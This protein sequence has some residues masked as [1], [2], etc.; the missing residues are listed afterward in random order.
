MATSG[1]G[2]TSY[3]SVTITNNTTG[4][5]SSVSGMG[6]DGYANA[7]ANGTGILGQGGH[8]TAIT[9]ITNSAAIISSGDGI[10]GWG[11]KGASAVAY[12]GGYGSSASGGLG[13]GGVARANVV[14]TNSGTI[15]SGKAEGIDGYAAARATGGVLGNPGSA[16]KAVGGTATS[17]L[18]ISNSGAIN[19]SGTGINDVA[20]AWAGGYGSNTGPSGT[21]PGGSG[22]G[23]TAVAG[24]I[25]TNLVGGT[26]YSTNAGGIDGYARAKSK[27]YGFKA[28]GGQATAT[29]TISNAAA[30]NS[31]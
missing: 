12:A 10:G 2:G 30:I 13:L 8:A 19:S 23:G 26:I 6:I 21:N 14:I 9:S 16:Y 20:K 7:E 1:T 22:T 15:S 27:G 3:G 28:Y 18:D 31:Q 25:I 11:G 29:T 17:N 4:T 5:I 24:I